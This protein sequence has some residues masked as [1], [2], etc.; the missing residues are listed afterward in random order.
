MNRH[1]LS[2]SW[3]LIASLPLA[4]LLVSWGE[5]AAVPADERLLAVGAVALAELLGFAPLLLALAI[6][7]SLSVGAARAGWNVRLARWG[8]I[9]FGGAAAAE[10]FRV[11]AGYRTFATH[12][13]FV[14][15]WTVLAVYLA[16]T[17]ATLAERRAR[18]RT[19]VVLGSV[20]LL[21][22]GASYAIG[23]A[24]FD[25][26]YPTLHLSLLTV[27]LLALHAGLGALLA[28][29]GR[30]ARLAPVAA[31]GAAAV[32]ALAAYGAG[33][34]TR[35]N[36]RALLLE[37]TAAGQVASLR[38]AA[39][40]AAAGSCDDLLDVDTAA[41]I[42][43][44]RS[45]LPRLPDDFDLSDYDVLLVLVETLRF[46]MTS[47]PGAAGASGPTPALRRLA[48]DGAL[49]MTRAYAPSVRTWLSL[50]SLWAMRPQSQVRMHT[51]VP[52]WFGDLDEAEHTAP[53]VFAEAGYDTFAV[54]H[55]FAGNGG[56]NQGF[57]SV[58]EESN[59]VEP[60]SAIDVN[61]AG[62]A[63]DAIAER[64][65]EK[66]FFGWLFFF[67]PHAPYLGEGDRRTRYQNAL[68]HT[69]RQL[70]RVLDH[71]RATGRLDRT[72]VIVTADH[73]EEI[74]EHGKRGHG[75][76]LYE[77]S[78]HVPLVIRI[79]GVPGGQVDTPV[80]IAHVLPWLFLRGDASMRRAARELLAADLGPL[81]EATDGEVVV[82]N[83]TANTNLVALIG[84]RTK[85][86]VNLRSGVHR[87][88]DLVTD[89][90]ER[91]DLYR[92]EPVLAERRDA[93]LARYRAHR[94]CRERVRITQDPRPQINRP[95]P[96]PPAVPY[97]PRHER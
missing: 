40:T 34:P 29:F 31:V 88:Y 69:D 70:G 27:R 49:S 4:L 2:H 43:A 8:A 55:G 21:A 62:R 92:A 7:A 74:E 93:L 89:P 94:A 65:G 95:D 44:A 18:P 79:P 38:P 59:W 25:S 19:L 96:F 73:G 77:E 42:F 68:A 67:S 26:R 46:D 58:H 48:A 20:G 75:T 91:T 87:I 3:P 12:L 16:V 81:L 11:L 23:S 28:S 13:P 1:A 39:T 10:S 72:I 90:G 97:E 60:R 53:E 78:I 82:E 5:W 80:S 36:P 64:A 14:G 86:I 50:S 41:E 66:R 17:C 32:V 35:S 54:R 22:A 57:A 52:P 6:G 24:H 47:L 76:T 84:E 85:S 61:I 33:V 71:L 51:K 56:M 9:G 15:A 45:G 83:W 30:G 37:Y 63:I